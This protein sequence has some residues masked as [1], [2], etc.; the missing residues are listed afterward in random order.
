[1]VGWITCFP[2]DQKR[3]V[4]HGIRRCCA[5]WWPT[6]LKGWWCWWSLGETYSTYIYT[7][8][9]Y[10]YLYPGSPLPPIFY[11]LVWDFH[12]II[13]K[14]NQHLE[15]IVDLQGIFMYTYISALGQIGEMTL[16]QKVAFCVFQK[17][18]GPMWVFFYV[19]FLP[20]WSGP[21][22]WEH[23]ITVDMPEN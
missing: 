7:V 23:G 14:K 1:M 3:G 18:L 15:K 17:E 9:I 6:F 22:N 4:R 10:I 16:F 19:V 21:T 2:S 8:N 12:H 11:R 5:H 13:Q 20:T